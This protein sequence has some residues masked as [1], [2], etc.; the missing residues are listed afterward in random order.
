MMLGSSSVSGC[1]FRGKFMAPSVDW[2]VEVIRSQYDDASVGCRLRFVFV[3]VVE[4]L[5]ELPAH[6]LDERAR[7]FAL[8][9]V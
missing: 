9:R 5:L 6:A 1:D 3:E 8:A 7:E 2:L 4:G